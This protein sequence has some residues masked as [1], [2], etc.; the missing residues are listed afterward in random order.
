MLVE[1]AFITTLDEQTTWSAAADLLRECGFT[2]SR[3][4]D[5][6]GIEAVRGQRTPQQA[7]T[8]SELPQEVRIAFDRGRVALAISAQQRHKSTTA[9]LGDM[10]VSLAE[11]L[12]NR[13][14]RGMPSPEAR[15]RWDDIAARIIRDRRRTVRTNTIVFLAIVGVLAG[16]ITFVATRSQ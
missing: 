7:K 13:I 10:L 3:R 1:H 15:A 8:I 11:A 16:L 2:I 4:Q 6:P 5:V 9:V 14:A 12:E